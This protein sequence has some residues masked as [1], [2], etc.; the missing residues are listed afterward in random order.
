MS[1]TSSCNK[2]ILRKHDCNLLG[3]SYPFF[4]YIAV[5]L[6]VFRSVGDSPE[7]Y[8]GWKI[9]FYQL[10]S[11]V[12]LGFYSKHHQVLTLSLG[13]SLTEM[14]QFHQQWNLWHVR[15]SHLS[16]SSASIASSLV[17]MNSYWRLRILAI[18]LGNHM[19]LYR[20]SFCTYIGTLFF[21]VW[22]WCTTRALFDF[23][24]KKAF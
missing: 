10:R 19:F 16:F 3:F 15:H 12:F 20:L 24:F 18:F 2:S 17:N 14:F 13:W 23:I 22:L 7:E 6:A 4:L 8:D 1:T 21:S 9:I 11:H 5:I